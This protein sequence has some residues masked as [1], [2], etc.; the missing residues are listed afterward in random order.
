MSKVQKIF[1]LTAYYAVAKRLPTQPSPGWKIGYWLR[2][3][4]VRQIFAECGEGV[5]VKQNCYFGNGKTLRVGSNSQLGVNARIQPS[6]TIGNDVLMGFD[7]IILTSTHEF[8]DPSTPVR[9][10]GYLAG[11]V[12]IGNDVWIGARVIIMPGVTIGDHSI[13]GAN[14]VV[15]RN[16][17]PLSVAAGMPCRVMRKR[18]ERL[19][20]N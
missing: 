2:R 4:L 10:Q 1:A 19:G 11:P 18:G 5:I 14:S 16:I 7:V 12:E 15:T 17:P 6:V 20:H 9:L 8:E 13:I 3:V